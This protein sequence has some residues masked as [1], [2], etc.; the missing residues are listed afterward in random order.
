MPRLRPALL[1]VLVLAGSAGCDFGSNPQASL[2]IA[3]AAETSVPTDVYLDQTRELDDAMPGTISPTLDTGV[4]GS[5][6][7]LVP[8]LPNSVTLGQRRFLDFDDGVSYVAVVV[9]TP[10]LNTRQVTLDTLTLAAFPVPPDGQ[11]RV[12]NGTSDPVDVYLGSAGT[13]ISSLTPVSLDRIGQI[14]ALLPTAAVAT[15]TDRGSTAV[16]YAVGVHSGT[17][18][19]VVGHSTGYVFDGPAPN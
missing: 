7:D 16:R 15:I 3:Y 6:F 9:G 1:A 12:V 18:V 10:H 2:Y 19:L 8:Q 13:P 5:R 11:L 14:S 17:D 4:G